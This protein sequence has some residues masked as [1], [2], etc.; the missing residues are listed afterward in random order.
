MEYNATMPET[1]RRF[2]T[3]VPT[4]NVLLQ[5]PILLVE[6]FWIKLFGNQLI[7]I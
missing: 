3:S 6:S 5:K 2:Y 4:T 1:V 7:V